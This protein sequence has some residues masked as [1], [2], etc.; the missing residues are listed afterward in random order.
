MIS[1]APG[2]GVQKASQIPRLALNRPSLC[3]YVV[4][5][6]LIKPETRHCE[7][8]IAPNA[9]NRRS[10]RCSSVQRVLLGAGSGFQSFAGPDRA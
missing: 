6:A 9:A 10:A 1:K 2:S 3:L 5:E 7:S 4:F 8:V